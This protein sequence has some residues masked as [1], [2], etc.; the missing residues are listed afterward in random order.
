MI[1]RRT[2]YSEDM[3]E[4]PKAESAANPLRCH[5]TTVAGLAQWRSRPASKLGR[6]T[7]RVP[8]AVENSRA[9][10]GAAAAGHSPDVAA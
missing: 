2:D 10:L 5:W 7:P 1:H 9:D 6:A 8:G 3:K 4:P